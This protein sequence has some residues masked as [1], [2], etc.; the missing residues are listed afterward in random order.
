VLELVS[1]VD[2]HGDVFSDDVDHVNS[3]SREELVVP[4]IHNEPVTHPSSAVHNDE[5][6]L[7]VDLEASGSSTEMS[8]AQHYVAHE[9]VQTSP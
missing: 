7:T 6:S 8:L 5:H 3:E 4:R 1:L 9:D 2:M